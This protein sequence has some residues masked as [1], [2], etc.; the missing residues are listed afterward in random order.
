MDFNYIHSNSNLYVRALTFHECFCNCICR[1]TEKMFFHKF[2]YFK[3]NK[4]DKFM[5]FNYIHSNS[6]LYVRALTFV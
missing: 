1:T 5:D 2:I 4:K 3:N 6:N